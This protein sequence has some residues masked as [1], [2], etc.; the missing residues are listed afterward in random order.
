MADL[1]YDP[2]ADHELDHN[3]RTSD[4][5]ADILSPGLNVEKAEGNSLCLTETFVLTS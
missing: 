1:S 4:V 5:G 2:L 3:R